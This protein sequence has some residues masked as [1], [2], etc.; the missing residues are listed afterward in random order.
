MREG[1]FW[2]CGQLSDDAEQQAKPMVG[3]AQ[4]LRQYWSS[5]RAMQGVQDEGTVSRNIW[6]AHPAVS[7]IA[8]EKR[9]PSTYYFWV[10]YHMNMVAASLVS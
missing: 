9:L 10:I 1:C 6:L 4:P 5:L 8:K 7:T 2:D 3:L